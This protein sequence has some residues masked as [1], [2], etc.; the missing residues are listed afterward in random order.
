[1]RFGDDWAGVFVRG[2]DAV[3]AGFAIE[4]VCDAAVALLTGRGPVAPAH[5]TLIHVGNLVVFWKLLQDS[6]ERRLHGRVQ[7]MRPFAECLK[8]GAVRDPGD[9]QPTEAEVVASRRF[10]QEQSRAV[11][12][13]FVTDV[14]HMPLGTLVRSMQTIGRVA[15]VARAGGHRWVTW[16]P[17]GLLG[18]DAGRK[19]TYE[20]AVERIDAMERELNR[21]EALAY[22]TE[23]EG[24]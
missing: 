20:D 14:R 11:L 5:E 2:D 24:A 12:A 18:T 13:I 21:R 6:D 7:E 1:M 19:V 4:R 10:V 15:H 17:A 16:L 8:E 22:V 9:E 3:C 23:R